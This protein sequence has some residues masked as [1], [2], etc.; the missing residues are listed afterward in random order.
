MFDEHTFRKLTYCQILE[1]HGKKLMTSPRQRNMI[2]IFALLPRVHPIKDTIAV[3]DLSQAID[4]ITVTTIGLVPTYATNSEFFCLCDGRFLNTM[5]I[6]YLMGHDVREL[7][8]I[9]V[10][11]SHFKHMLG[12]GFHVSSIGFCLVGLIA[13]TA[14]GAD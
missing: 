1:L 14:S 2:N 13:S 8:M 7:N 3:I 6:A 4:R 9:G 5:Q 12:I 10:C 11:E